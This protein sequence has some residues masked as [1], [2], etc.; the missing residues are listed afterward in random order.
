M[1]LF[2][3]LLHCKKVIMMEDDNLCSKFL[4]SGLESSLALLPA[5]LAARIIV[6]K[7]AP[8]AL[9]HNSYLTVHNLYILLPTRGF[10][11]P[12]LLY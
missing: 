4:Q 12:I 1:H 5:F 11:Y 2:A 9:Y 10:S 7:S 3:I 8:Y 6:I